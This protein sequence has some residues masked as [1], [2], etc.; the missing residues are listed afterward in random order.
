MKQERIAQEEIAEM[1][2]RAALPRKSGEIVFHNDWER[3]S[4][5]LA[6]SLAEQG[7]FEWNE[8]QSELISAIKEAEG[9]NPHHPSRGYFE[10]WL[11]SLESLLEKKLEKS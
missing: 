10:S 2:G 11:I 8:F 5:A 6:V 1:H 4:F 7:L 3:K 9:D